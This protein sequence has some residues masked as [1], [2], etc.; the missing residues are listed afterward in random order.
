MFLLVLCHHWLISVLH[1]NIEIR[2]VAQRLKLLETIKVLNLLNRYLYFE[3]DIPYMLF[4]DLLCLLK[5]VISIQAYF[6][7]IKK[8]SY[9]YELHKVYKDCII[10][11]FK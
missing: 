10:N 2:C 11:D 3:T 5:A 4:S 9:L 6:H 7:P 8:T 1:F